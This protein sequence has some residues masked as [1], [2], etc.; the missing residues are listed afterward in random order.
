MV[1]KP[2]IYELGEA[3]MNR[4][5]ILL[6]RLGLGLAGGFLMQRIFNL[7]G[8]WITALILAALIIAAAYLSEAWRLKKQIKDKKP[9]QDE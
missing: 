1:Q 7:Q 9:P 4:G 3:L 2:G 5:M 6:M 8:G